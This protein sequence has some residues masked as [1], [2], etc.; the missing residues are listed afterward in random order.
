MTG[1]ATV[2]LLTD[3]LMGSNAHEVSGHPERPERLQP[4]IDGVVAGAEEA[5]AVL[6]GPAVAPATDEQIHRIHP[7]WFVDALDAMP[8]SL[9]ALGKVR[10]VAVSQDAFVCAGERVPSV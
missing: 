8:W 4:V 2:V 7:A 5:G 3:E 10:E 6:D 9:L 1:A